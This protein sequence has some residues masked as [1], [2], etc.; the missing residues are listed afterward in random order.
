MWFWKGVTLLFQPRS[1][2]IIPSLYL[3]YALTPN[4]TSD[5]SS[6]EPLPVSPFW[7]S[8]SDVILPAA[9]PKA[10]HQLLVSRIAQSISE[11]QA[12]TGT[13]VSGQALNKNGLK[14]CDWWCQQTLWKPNNTNLMIEETS[15]CSFSLFLSTFMSVTV[16]ALTNTINFETLNRPNFKLYLLFLK[17]YPLFCAHNHPH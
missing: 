4:T 17:T 13:T 1:P 16:Y 12:H 6:P 2:H 11:R 7:S 5:H 10:A 8:W 9:S 15:R 3:L 14:P